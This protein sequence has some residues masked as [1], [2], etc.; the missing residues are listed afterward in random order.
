LANAPQATGLH[1]AL[2]AIRAA[3]LD[4]SPIVGLTHQH[5]KYP[6]RFAPAFARAAIEAFSNDG[7]LIL[8]PYMGGGTTIVE[9]LASGRR[10]IGCD[11]NSL[12]VFVAK[13]KTTVL[14]SREVHE[15]ESWLLEVV[16]FRYQD[17]A[18][19]IEDHICEARTRNLHLPRARAIKKFIA[20]CLSVCDSLMSEKSKSFARCALL[21]VTQW[22]LNGRRKVVTL[23]HFRERLVKKTVEMLEASSE[24]GRMG[25]GRRTPSFFHG[26]AEHLPTAHPFRS[27]VKVDL[28]VTS[29]PY[30]GIHILYHRWQVDGRRE[31]PAPYWIAGCLDGQGTAHYNFGTRSGAGCENYFASSFRTLKSIRGVMRPGS[32]IV[33]MIAFSDARRQL[34]RYLANMEAAGFSEVRGE[35][36]RF[37][38]IW[39]DVPRRSWHADLQGRTG[40]AREVVLIHRAEGAVGS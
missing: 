36:E 28:V 26:S 10:A 39:R 38:R 11:I 17:K 25:P 18:P 32:L 8:D 29:P 23:N 21:N 16:Q 19:W 4:P 24:L 30:P 3:A 13:V 1:E 34:S 35:T 20:H 27:G 15:V 31:T 2:R 33:Q 40:G 37:R 9:A 7:D 6:G 22:A 5:Y 12:A 14:S